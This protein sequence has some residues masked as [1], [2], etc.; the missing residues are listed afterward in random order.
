MALHSLAILY[1]DYFLTLPVEIA[2][3]WPPKH[4]FTWASSLFLANRYLSLFGHIPVIM[5]SF[6][7]G[8]SVKARVS[9]ALC[10]E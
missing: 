8:D 3:F 1:Y 4:R 10:I 7:D 2:Y 6:M 5:E 9:L